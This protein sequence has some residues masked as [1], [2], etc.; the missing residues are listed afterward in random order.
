MRRT[1]SV[2]TKAHC[3]NTRLRQTVLALCVFVLFSVSL[4]LAA[5]DGEEPAFKDVKLPPVKRIVLYNSG[6][7]QLQHEGKIE[8]RGKVSL[9]FG[10]H[11][12]SDAL[13]SLAIADDNGGNVRS[14][15]YQPAPDPEILAAND[16]GQPMTIAQLLQVMRGEAIVLSNGD[17][18]IKGD[19]FGVENRTEGDVT[20]EMIVVI[21]EDGLS[22]HK[23]TDFE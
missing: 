17:S 13:K 16:I 14:I 21:T 4:A 12:V 10:S 8:G 18:E 7:G 9:R 5:Q 1:I 22:S 6:V 20:S 11:D 19:I 3:V 23:L 2:L 15:E